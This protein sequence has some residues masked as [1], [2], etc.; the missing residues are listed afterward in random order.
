[1]KKPKPKLNLDQMIRRSMTPNK[2]ISELQ[3]NKP[4]PKKKRKAARASRRRNR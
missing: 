1:M 2:R 3:P 4:D